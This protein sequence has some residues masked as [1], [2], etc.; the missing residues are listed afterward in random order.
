MQKQIPRIEDSAR[1]SIIVPTYKE[2]ENLGILI[3]RIAAAMREAGREFEIIVVDDNSGD[4]TEEILAKS[5]HDGNPVK[6]ITRVNERGLSSAVLEGFRHAQGSILV[7]MDADLSHPPEALPQLV[8]PLRR[9]GVDF[10]I[11]SRYVPGASTGEDWGVFRWLNSKFATLLARPFTKIKDPMAGFFAL[12]RAVFERAEKLNPVGYKI[13]LELIVKCGCDKSCREIPIHFAN[14]K[15]GQSK[16]SV[17]EQLR[18]I[19]HLKRLADYK[20]GWLSQFVRFSL[21]GATGVAVDLTSYFLLLSFAVDPIVRANAVPAPTAKILG[22]IA[23]IVAIVSAMTHNFYWNLRFTF[24]RSTQKTVL[25][26]YWNFVI[27][28]S[29]G[30]LVNLAISRGLSRTVGFFGA[31]PIYAAFIGILGGVL[32]NF[33]FSRNWVFAGNKRPAKPA[34]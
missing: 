34:I 3:P 27:A 26:Q 21:V 30:S 25:R 14:R 31:H 32:S 19:M 24:G 23:R 17:R 8:E 7:C 9:P 12:P 18:Y 28:C 13:A 33:L 2:A 4:G 29:F 20:F 5:A 16:L 15:Y 22:D 6:L 1:V 11:G 10:V